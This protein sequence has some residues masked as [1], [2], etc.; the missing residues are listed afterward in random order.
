MADNAAPHARWT[1]QAELPWAPLMYGFSLF[2]CLATARSQ[3]GEGLGTMWGH[4]AA[5]DP[6][7]RPRASRTSRATG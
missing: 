6:A 7:A 3:G 1:A 4:E 5:E 2:G